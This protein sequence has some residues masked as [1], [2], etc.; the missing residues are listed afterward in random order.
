M[1]TGYEAFG[2][3]QALKLHFTT[4]QFDFFK[5]NGKTNISVTSFENR[6]D[7]YFF[8]KLSRK[9]K[10]KKA[11]TDFIV[12]NMIEDSKTWAGSLLDEQAEIHCKKHEKIIQSLSYTFK[13]DCETLFGDSID[14]NEHLLIGNG[15]Y[16]TLLRT[17]LHKD[18]CL[19]TFCI[20]NRL[21][22]FVPMWTKKINDTI[23]WPQFRMTALKY[24]PFIHADLDKCKEILRN[25]LNAN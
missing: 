12:Y 22:N 5:Y 13:N 21:L 18:I 15:E 8:Y 11:L 14:P 19:E 17:A 16:P 7:K 25:V 4:E 10:D 6:K 3:Y 23:H 1:I 9:Y 20:L 2:L 24:T